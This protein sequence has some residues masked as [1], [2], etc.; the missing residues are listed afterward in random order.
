MIRTSVRAAAVMAS[1]ASVP[2]A[3]QE[4]LAPPAAIAAPVEAVL[5]TDDAEPELPKGAAAGFEPPAA[6]GAGGYLTPNRGL[7]GEETTW[8]LRVALNVAALGCRGAL[9]DG[10]NALLTTHKAALAA[11][12]AAVTMRYKARFGQ[13]WQAQQDDAMTR[14]YNFWA[15]PPAQAAFC[16][17]ARAVLAEA[18]AITPD[19]L[20]GFAATALPRIE[21]PL[22]AFFA[23]YDR[24]RTAHAGWAARH[25]RGPAAAPMVAPMV[26]VAAVT[27][28]R[29][30]AGEP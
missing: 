27:R 9:V 20:P 22:I 30:G 7:S 26:A 13:G 17:A 11:T 16:T 8:H 6:D 10:Y 14:L 12:A 2:A 29:I 15:L 5:V 1:L 25:A 28:M 4:M 3:A 19:A 24:W 23:D 21:A 18:A